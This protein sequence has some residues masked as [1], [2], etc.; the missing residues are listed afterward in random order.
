MKL[1][2]PGLLFVCVLS[3]GALLLGCDKD[4]S[5]E[6]DTALDLQRIRCD[7]DPPLDYDNYGSSFL[8]KN[9]SGCHSSEI[10]GAMRAGAPDNIDFNE[11]ELAAQWADRIWERA[12][13]Q[14]DMPPGGGPTSDELQLLAEWITCDSLFD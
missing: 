10:T 5:G 4:A 7:R 13:V 14:G 12:L 3:G 2:S 1:G 8:A 9:C 11:P 6:A